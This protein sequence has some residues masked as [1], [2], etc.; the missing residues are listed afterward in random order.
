MA[1][2]RTPVENFDE[3]EIRLI[4]SAITRFGDGEHPLPTAESLEFFLPEYV[5]ECLRQARLHAKPEYHPI[6][7]KILLEKL[8]A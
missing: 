7:D 6:I 4:C 5:D 3:Q 1:K 2:A 8:H